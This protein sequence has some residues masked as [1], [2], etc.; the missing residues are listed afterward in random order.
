MHIEFPDWAVII[1]M[2]VD[3]A[4][5]TFN[6]EIMILISNIIICI[7]IA[8]IISILLSKKITK[9]V[10]LLKNYVDDIG[11]DHIESKIQIKSNNEIGDLAIAFSD[12]SKNLKHHQQNLENIVKE[13]TLQLET[14]IEELQ[15]FKKV[16]I[17]REI[18]MIELKKRIKELEES[19]K[20]GGRK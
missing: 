14:K 13:R 16:T 1:E 8:V 15:R 9:P 7:I 4:Y 10:L 5:A 18:K 20:N 11:K 17:D 2:P 3:E 6:R 12:M 19:I